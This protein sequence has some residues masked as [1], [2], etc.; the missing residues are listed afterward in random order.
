MATHSSIL[1]WRIPW[2]EEPGGLQSMGHKEMDMAE[3]R[4]HMSLL[5]HQCLQS[6]DNTK[7]KHQVTLTSRD[8]LINIIP[9]QLGKHSKNIQKSGFRI[10]WDSMLFYT[11][12]HNS[13]DCTL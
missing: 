13:K 4:V 6:K 11:I 2:T 12:R 8:H 3:T 9:L 10:P 5:P 7:N 1:A